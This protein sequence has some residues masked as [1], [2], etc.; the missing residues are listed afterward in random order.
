MSS[1]Q[2]KKLVYR[3]NKEFIEGGNMETFYEIFAED[4]INHS[5]PA[6]LPN[7]R[8]GVVYFFNHLLKPSFPDLT[9]EIHDMIAEG[10]KVSTH[11]SFYG[12]HCGDFFGIPPTNKKVVMD[13]MDIIQ[14]QDGKY[15]G[16]WGILDLHSL[17][18]QIAD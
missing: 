17:M 3:V 4:F 10:D 9:V 11:K 6:G 15:T 1:A 8:E 16:H 14:I 5:A 18:A 12:T 7:N 13:V 2:N